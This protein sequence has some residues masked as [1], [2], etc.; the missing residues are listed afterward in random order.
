MSQSADDA[1]DLAW[2]RRVQRLD[3]RVAFAHLL[4]RHQSGVRGLLRRLTQGDAALADELAQECF[5]SAYQAMAGFRGEAKVKTWLY[6]IA[7][8]LFLQQRR[9]SA[10]RPLMQTLDE[11]V[12]P[13]AAEGNLAGDVALSLDLQLAMRRLSEPERE[14]IACC[15]AADLSHAEAAELLG[16]RLGT[17]KTHVLRAK[18]KLRV[19]LAAWEPKSASKERAA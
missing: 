13:A 15:Y 5:L 3:D 1:Q 7:Y 14:A 8:N 2:V 10:A 19:A 12:P 16:W 11:Q 18:A 9:S 6:R 17:L 4:R